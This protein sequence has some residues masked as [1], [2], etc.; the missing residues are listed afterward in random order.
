MN[1]APYWQSRFAFP[2]RG[3]GVGASTASFNPKYLVDKVQR[4]GYHTTKDL[5]E[6]DKE[7]SNDPQA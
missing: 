1:Q 4:T 5:V 6:L 7:A 2:Q 3:A